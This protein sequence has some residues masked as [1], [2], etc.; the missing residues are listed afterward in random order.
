VEPTLLP[1]RR[2]SSRLLD[3]G[4]ALTL[5]IAQAARIT[6]QVNVAGAVLFLIG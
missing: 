5:R 2:L 4:V 3:D 6:A 1:A